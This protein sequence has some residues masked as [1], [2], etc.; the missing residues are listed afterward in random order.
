MMP[1][2]LTTHLSKQLLSQLCLATDGHPTVLS[3]GNDCPQS[4]SWLTWLAEHDP[5]T[6]WQ[7]LQLE[8]VAGQPSI[9]TT[10][11]KHPN[12]MAP[13][14][15]NVRSVTPPSSSQPSLTYA[16]AICRYPLHTLRWVELKRLFYYVNQLLQ[17]K[18]RVLIC[19]Y[20]MRGYHI[21]PEL[22]ALDQSLRQRSQELGVRDVTVINA[23]AG[24]NE[25]T[26][27]QTM[28][29]A[30]DYYCLAYVKQPYSNTVES[31]QQREP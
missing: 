21:R 14:T 11:A 10:V 18:A 8:T 1:P 29:L 2:S 13:L 24:M 31:R 3:L 26:L 6:Q 23:L 7:P 9:E 15:L 5:K 28:T 4:R 22:L 20:M 25:L 19:D 30:P 17:A 12:M 16:G 27:I